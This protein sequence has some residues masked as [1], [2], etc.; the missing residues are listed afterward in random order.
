MYIYKITFN[1]GVSYIG[2][3]AQSAG[4]R[5]KSHQYLLSIGKHKNKRLQYAYDIFGYP[6]FSVLEDNIESIE[7]LNSREIYWISYY[8]TYT[9]GCNQTP[10]GDNASYTGASSHNAIYTEDDYIAIFWFLAHT[11]WTFKEIASELEVSYA[12]V[13]SINYGNS[14]TYLR[15]LMPQEQELI[16]NKYG[17]RNS[18]RKV[19]P[20]IKSPEGIIYTVE[21]ATSFARLYGLTASNLLNVLNGKRRSCM[22]WTLADPELRESLT[23]ESIATVI[24]PAGVELKV[25]SSATF[26]E[27]HELN[28][29]AFARMLSGEFS[30]HKGWKLKHV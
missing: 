28:K 4:T 2:Q 20:A 5:E 3:T 16:E 12:V 19:F 13:Q 8:D 14:H 17:K 27:K 10:G 26:A 1:S 11:N 15:K 18:L 23:Q 25:Y 7:V 22:G 24:S 30:S 21:C 9:N 29:T 6:E